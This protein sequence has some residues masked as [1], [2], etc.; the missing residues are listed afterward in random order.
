MLVFLFGSLDCG[1]AVFSNLFTK[2]DFELLNTLLKPKHVSQKDGLV[3]K[4][5]KQPFNVKLII[6][7]CFLQ[8]FGIRRSQHF[9]FAQFLPDG[10]WQ[11]CQA[12]LWRWERQWLTK[13]RQTLT[14]KN[15]DVVILTTSFR[16]SSQYFL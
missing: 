13:K 2:P 15:E 16:N 10:I 11:T 1:P 9:C 6:F 3:C 14:L 4:S 12:K 7:V 5:K 8:I